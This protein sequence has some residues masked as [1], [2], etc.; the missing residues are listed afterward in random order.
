MDYIGKVNASTL[1]PLSKVVF[2]DNRQADLESLITYAQP[3]LGWPEPPSTGTTQKR[4]TTFPPPHSDPLIDST[5]YPHQHGSR[6]RKP[7]DAAQHAPF[8]VPIVTTKVMGMR[9]RTTSNEFI[10]SNSKGQSDCT[11]A[12]DNTVGVL[13]STPSSVIARA[14]QRSGTWKEDDRYVW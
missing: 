4:N 10:G 2:A 7:L 13:R 5:G 1:K 9:F 8:T 14:Y 12:L 6:L 11:E 3:H